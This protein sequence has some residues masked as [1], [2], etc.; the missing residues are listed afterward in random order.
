MLR[1]KGFFWVAA[2]HRVAYQ[3]AQA[4]GVLSVNPVGLWWAAV[5]Q[6][7]M[8]IPE[9]S[10]PDNQADWHDHYGDRKQMLV[11][12]GQDMDEAAIRGMLDD[13]LLASP[14]AEAEFAQWE[15]RENPFPPLVLPDEEAAED[16]S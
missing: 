3:F 12:I 14:L 1:A 10:R 11:F 6:E 8:D 7:A 5:D 15:G 2:D 4:G 13:C 16:E 9:E